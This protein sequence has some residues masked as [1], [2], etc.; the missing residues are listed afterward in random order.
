M[1][2]SLT[3]TELWRVQECLENNNQS[4]I[5]WKQRGS[6]LF[7][8][9]LRRPDL[10]HIPTKLHEDIPNGYWVM[11][12]TRMLTDVRTDGQLQAIIRRFFFVFFLFLFFFFFQRKKQQQIFLSVSNF[13]PSKVDGF[14]EGNKDQR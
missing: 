9:A 12:R 4:G 14:S 6:K 1:K 13:C 3:V 5:T 11:R 7:L 10:I 2:I 8:C